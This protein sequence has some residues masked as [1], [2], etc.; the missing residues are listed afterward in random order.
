MT[1]VFLAIL[2]LAWIAVFLPALMKAREAAPISTAQRFKQRLEL[3]APARTSGRWV[4]VPGAARR[5]TRSRERRTREQRKAI[6]VALL[7]VATTSG[8][9]AMVAGGALWEVHFAL[10]GSLALFVALLLEDKRRRR[11]R[12]AKVRSLAER[13]SARRVH[14]SF[15]G[16]LQA[17]ARSR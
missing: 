15:E 16:F 4:V 1:L 10:D 14:P 3:I 5:A 8:L 2:A 17:E 11:E 12:A 13:R 7:V 9:A 6:F